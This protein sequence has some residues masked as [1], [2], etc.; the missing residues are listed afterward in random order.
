MHYFDTSFLAPLFLLE[1]KS[2]YVEGIFQSVQSDRFVSQCLKVEFASVIARNQRM[3]IF[4]KLQATQ[5]M[6][7]F[8]ILLTNSFYML[9]PT[10]IDFN[11]ATSL[12]QHFQTGLR[13]GDALHLAIA[14]N[15]GAKKFYTL[16]KVLAQAAKE[17]TSLQVVS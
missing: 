5:I 15:H 13:A 16:D 9:L 12:L 4:N 11:L 3:K 2:N 1:D 14:Q 8:E 6:E 10:V 7:N 17:L